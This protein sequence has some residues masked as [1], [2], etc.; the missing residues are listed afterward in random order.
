MEVAILVEDD[1]QLGPDAAFQSRALLHSDRTIF[2]HESASHGV[3]QG[4]NKLPL[5]LAAGAA[6]MRHDDRQ[7]P[8]EFVVGQR[9]GKGPCHGSSL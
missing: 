4:C 8:A 3:Q 6:P 5:L 2:A 9:V 1:Q 7:E